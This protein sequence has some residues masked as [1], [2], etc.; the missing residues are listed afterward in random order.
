MESKNE[1]Q[2]RSLKL[3]AKCLKAASSGEAISLQRL[4][5][6]AQSRYYLD[7]RQ[8]IYLRPL[9]R[10]VRVSESHFKKLRGWFCMY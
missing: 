5:Q 3:R 6:F 4:R 9:S 10:S 1:I 2:K 8:L 7:A